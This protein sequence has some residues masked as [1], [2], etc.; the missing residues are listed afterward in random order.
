MD[1]GSQRGCGLSDSPETESSD[2]SGYRH[3]GVHLTTLLPQIRG[4]QLF[5]GTFGRKTN[6][7][8]LCKT[9]L[10]C[11]SHDTPLIYI[12]DCFPNLDC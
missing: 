5:L 7:V 11:H 1:T 2:E 12:F 3:N 10:K 4:S 6:T 8:K 9:L